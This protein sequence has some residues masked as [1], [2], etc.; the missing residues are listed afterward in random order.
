M[1]PIRLIKRLD[2]AAALHFTDP[3]GKH[4]KL[5]DGIC[6]KLDAAGHADD[7]WSDDNVIQQAYKEAGEKRYK[8]DVELVG[9]VSHK[10][11]ESESIIC[12]FV[13]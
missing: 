13:V 9:K 4:K 5:L 11:K 3:D 8:I 12:L 2:L 7:K 1:V 10:S 6:A